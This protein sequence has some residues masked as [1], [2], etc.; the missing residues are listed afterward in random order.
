[1]L[2]RAALLKMPF[3]LT[4]AIREMH[5]PFSLPTMLKAFVVIK[6]LLSR[7]MPVSKFTLKYFSKMISN[8][9]SLSKDSPKSSGTRCCAS[10]GIMRW[11]SRVP[12]CLPG[13]P[14]LWGV[15]GQGPGL[16]PKSWHRAWPLGYTQAVFVQE[17]GGWMYSCVGG[18]MDGQ[19][20]GWI[21][22]GWMDGWMDG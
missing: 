21:V 11:G 5:R 4:A 16:H 22:D 10:M 18:W 9:Y 14:G 17:M 2:Y 12:P 8:V 19:V 20:D 13:T 6:L 1:M 15:G 3:I 7:G